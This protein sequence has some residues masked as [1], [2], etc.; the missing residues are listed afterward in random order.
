M[1]KF[2]QSCSSYHRAHNAVDMLSTSKNTMISWYKNNMLKAV[3]QLPDL[4][5]QMPR[6]SSMCLAKQLNKASQS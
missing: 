4:H 3:H 2:N 1:M 5:Y 6:Q